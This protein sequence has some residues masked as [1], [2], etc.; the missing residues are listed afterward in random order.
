MGEV[1]EAGPAEIEAALAAAARFAAE[2]Q[3]RSATERGDCLRKA[4]DLFEAH[5]HEL[6]ALALREAG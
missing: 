2:W 1:R 4:A 6:I 5:R 3:Q